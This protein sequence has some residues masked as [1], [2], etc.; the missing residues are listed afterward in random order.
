[1]AT[2]TIQ[3]DPNVLNHL[4][5]LAAECGV[6]TPVYCQTILRR[7]LRQTI[8]KRRAEREL[9]ALAADTIEVASK[10]LERA[11]ELP[12]VGVK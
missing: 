12:S 1:M 5:I 10:Y 9:S 11:V 4:G 3:D 6:S 2:I 8:L 7:H